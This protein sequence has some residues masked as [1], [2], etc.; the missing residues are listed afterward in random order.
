MFVSSLREESSGWLECDLMFSLCAL[1]G[2][3]SAMPDED[4]GGA[5]DD[6]KV[7]LKISI[8]L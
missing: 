7:R 3:S 5:S 8:T 4:A 2:K 6:G 1:G